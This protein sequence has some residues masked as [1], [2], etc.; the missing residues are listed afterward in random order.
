V[1]GPD[2]ADLLEL[3]GNVARA[4]G[5]LLR[6]RPVDLAVGTKSSPTDVVTVMDTAAERLILDRIRAD[7]PDDAVL[8]EESGAAAG[9]SPVRW[10]VDPLDGTVNYLYRIPQYAVSIAAEIDGRV[11]AGVVYAPES[12]ELFAACLG[13]GAS[14]N[15][16]PLRCSA[17]DDLAQALVATGFGYASARR[18][19]QAAVLGVVLPKVRDIRRFGAAALDLVAVGAG[20]VDAFYER[21]LRPWDLA[22]GGLIATEAGA[23]VGGLAGESAGEDLVI[24]APPALFDELARL[25]APLGADRDD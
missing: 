10:L 7:R 3:A 13:G 20:R 23:V 4:A 17:Q 11:V 19:R 15:G 24:A 22:A 5:A 2:P 8:A 1:V 18:A 21:G 9:D 16:R 12:D 25:L 14:C 6:D